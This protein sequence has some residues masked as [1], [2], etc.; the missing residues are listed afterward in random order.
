[1]SLK[2]LHRIYFG[3]DGNPDPYMGFLKTWQEQLPGY[4]IIHWN[5]DNL[6]MNNCRFSQEMLR[7]RD[8]AFLSDYYRWWVLR[9]H[10][11]IYLDADIEVVD[12]AGFNMIVEELE[13]SDQFDA[14]IGIDNK[15]GGWYTGHSVASKKGSDYAHFMCEVYESFGAISVWRRKVFYFMS[16]QL[17]ALYFGYNGYHFDGMGSTPGLTTPI[18][19]LRV[20]IY[21]Q[22]Y[23]SP[24]TPSSHEGKASFT[25]NAFTVNTMLCH[26]FSCSWHDADSPYLALKGATPQGTVLLRDL[27][28]AG[29]YAPPAEPGPIQRLARRGWRVLPAQ[30]R[31]RVRQTAPNLLARLRSAIG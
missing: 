11:G 8:H 7:L 2:K 3:F 14:F 26:H 29:L 15:E 20:K 27:V 12:G 23:F 28:R 22:E 17:S 6:P 13:V 16:P 31:S 21:P 24:M 19:E 30:V 18:V 5:A 9:E 4:E 10:G 25:I 1:M